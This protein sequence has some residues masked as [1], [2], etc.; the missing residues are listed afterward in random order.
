M[1]SYCYIK[2]ISKTD[3]I[4]SK[5]YNGMTIAYACDIYVT[6]VDI[7]EHFHSDKT[8]IVPCYK[9]SADINKF[10]PYETPHIEVIS[11]HVE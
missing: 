8:T 7:I 4:I 2:S 5:D 3:S 9:M 6:I 1:I 11:H 10:L